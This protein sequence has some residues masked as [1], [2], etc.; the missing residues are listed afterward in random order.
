MKWDV[1][2]D[3]DNQWNFCFNCFFNGRSSLLGSDIY[4]CSVWL[5]L[6]LSLKLNLA[7]LLDNVMIREVSE[8]TISLTARTDGSTGSPRCSPSFPGFTPPTIR[9]P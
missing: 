6:F 3:S 4:D 2:G 8:S 7:L 1:L 9:V 5:Q